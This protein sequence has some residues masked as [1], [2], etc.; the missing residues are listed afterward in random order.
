MQRKKIKKIINQHWHIFQSDERLEL[1]QDPP[2]TLFKRGCNLV[3]SVLTPQPLT[4][5]TT[6]TFI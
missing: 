4:T 2:L 3:R 6:L 5:Q 1:V